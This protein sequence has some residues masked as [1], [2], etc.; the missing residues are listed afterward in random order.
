MADLREQRRGEWRVLRRRAWVATN[1]ALLALVPMAALPK[2]SP[3]WC[4]SVV[5]L[6][7]NQVARIIVPDPRRRGG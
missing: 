1:L 5:V 7:A 4:Y 6:A 3:W 2:V